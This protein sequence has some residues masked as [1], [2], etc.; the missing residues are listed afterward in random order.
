MLAEVTQLSEDE[1]LLLSLQTQCSLVSERDLPRQEIV[2][3]GR[4][5]K[6][7]TRS[8]WG[9]PS[10]LVT[11]PT[12]AT[13]EYVRLLVDKMRH[14]F[15]RDSVAESNQLLLSEKLKKIL[16]GYQDKLPKDAFD[17]VLVNL[18]Y[19]Q[20][21]LYKHFLE[22]IC[23]RIQR[24]QIETI[25]QAAQVAEWLYDEI[26]KILQFHK[27]LPPAI[28]HEAET[29]HNHSYFT[30]QEA[31]VSLVREL[32]RKFGSC[33]FVT[34][35]PF[36][37]F[38]RL[39]SCFTEFV[40]S[41]VALPFSLL[42]QFRGFCDKDGDTARK[43]VCE[44]LAYFVEQPLQH[45]QSLSHALRAFK[46][47]DEFLQFPVAQTAACAIESNFLARVKGSHRPLTV[48]YGALGKR[49]VALSQYKDREKFGLL[50]KWADAIPD[51]QAVL[52]TFAMERLGAIRVN[53]VSLDTE[54]G[55]FQVG[56][57]MFD[58]VELCTT[59]ANIV[60]KKLPR[61]HEFDETLLCKAIGE[62]LTIATVEH[63]PMND[64]CAAWAVL[65]LLR[66][67]REL[68]L[69]DGVST[70]LQFPYRYQFLFALGNKNDFVVT[71]KTY[72]VAKFVQK[73][74]GEMQELQF[75]VVVDK[76][77]MLNGE[78]D[79]QWVGQIHPFIFYLEDRARVEER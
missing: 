62:A 7:Q 16:F 13:P 76:S 64:L 75:E 33:G 28:I 43:S 44:M 78:Q 45:H 22:G 54:K 56:K 72:H 14:A 41:G 24:E 35:M 12:P 79:S 29:L 1:R 65:K 71:V 51:L 38:Q 37:P 63:T 53:G 59:V 20:L 11:P 55:E 57:E 3:D 23:E 74:S 67:H 25:S 77:F 42:L 17:A 21:M 70:T 26:Q 40:V 4:A 61:S 31:I 30:F 58:M 34:N 49:E 39:W 47:L 6:V 18:L 73:E 2:W 8:S 9:W 46:R 52:N 5:F 60:R 36:M 10:F 48:K 69:Q 66:P 68:I 32:C 15:T 50:R 27:S 19:H